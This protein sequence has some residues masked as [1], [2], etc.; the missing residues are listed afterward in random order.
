[1]STSALP[2]WS[3][4]RARVASPSRRST[5]RTPFCASSWAMPPHSGIRR[6]TRRVWWQEF[7]QHLQNRRQT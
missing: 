5:L 1:M 2:M 7:H 3:S 6:A 4:P